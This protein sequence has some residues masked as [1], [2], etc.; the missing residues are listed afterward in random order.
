MRRQPKFS[1]DDVDDTEESRPNQ[2]PM[3]GRGSVSAY[4]P[5]STALRDRKAAA[6]N[7][8]PS[9]MSLQYAQGA[10]KAF[11]TQATKSDGVVANPSLSQLRA[12]DNQEVHDVPEVNNDTLFFAPSVGLPSDASWY[13]MGLYGIAT[14]TAATVSEAQLD[15]EYES[16]MT[17][18]AAICSYG[19]TAEDSSDGGVL[20][21]ELMDKNMRLQFEEVQQILAKSAVPV[22]PISFEPTGTVGTVCYTSLYIFTSYTHALIR[23]SM[24]TLMNSHT[25]LFMQ[26]CTRMRSCAHAHKP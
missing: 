10:A 4:K 12:F 22:R 16:L 26:Y 14:H 24:H 11:R 1:L 23:P 25:H 20:Q 6:T 18:G 19:S 17:L 13:G 5:N 8:K 9:T 2:S 3:A 7:S 21:Q 15:K